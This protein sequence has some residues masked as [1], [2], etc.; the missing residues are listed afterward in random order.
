MIFYWSNGSTTCYRAATKPDRV[1]RT[2][3]LFRLPYRFIGFLHAL[4]RA[5]DQRG[6]G[7][8]GSRFQLLIKTLSHPLG[9]L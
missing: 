2:R 3:T 1:D 5:F 4:A 9:N 6:V 8:S 7:V